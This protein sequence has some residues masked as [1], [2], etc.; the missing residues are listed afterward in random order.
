M[1]LTSCQFKHSKLCEGESIVN[2]H[3]WRQEIDMTGD[4]SKLTI[5]VFITMN[6]RV[7][8]YHYAILR[9]CDPKL[10]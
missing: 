8:G 1:I 4:N 2:I 3:G 7:L 5:Q 10:F 9:Y 6:P